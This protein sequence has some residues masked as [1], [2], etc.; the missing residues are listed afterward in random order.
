MEEMYLIDMLLLIFND[1]ENINN[2]L[3][4]LKQQ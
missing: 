3:I 1:T 2:L 4:L